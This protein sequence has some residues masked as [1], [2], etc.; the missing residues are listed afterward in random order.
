MS[1]FIPL[2]VLLLPAA[3]SAGEERAP[4]RLFAVTFNNTSVES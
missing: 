3:T 1:R 2:V 4:D